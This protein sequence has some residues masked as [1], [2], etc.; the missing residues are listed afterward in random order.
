MNII[1]T[2]GMV[3]I[4]TKSITYGNIRNMYIDNKDG[5]GIQVDST[6]EDKRD[7]ALDI[8]NQISDLVYKLQDLE[9]NNSK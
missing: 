9:K 4:D 2:S 7:E 5:V 6:L 1:V 3:N 8:C